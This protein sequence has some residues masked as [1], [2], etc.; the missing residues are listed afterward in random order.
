MRLPIA[1]KTKRLDIVTTM[2][3]R[4]FGIGVLSSSTSKEDESPPMWVKITLRA[5]VLSRITA[6]ELNPVP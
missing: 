2:P 1:A 5:T 6:W 3:G 4:D